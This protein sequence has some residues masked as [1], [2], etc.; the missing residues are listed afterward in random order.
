M[1]I[2]MRLALCC[3]LTSGAFA[4]HHGSSGS[5]GR[6][7]F[8]GSSGRG[9]RGHAGLHRNLVQRGFGNNGPYGSY[10]YWPGYWDSGLW[11][12]SY[13]DPSDTPSYAGP[14]VTVVYPPPAPAYPAVVQTAHPVIHEYNQP[15][16]YGL[17]GQE[18]HPVLYLIAFRDSVIRPATTFWVEGDTLHYIG[19]DHKEQRAPLSSVDEDLSTELNRERHVPFHL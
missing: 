14:N 4:Q 18:S 3:L 8:T 5:A 6:A 12:S 7:G 2:V 15:E 1:K 13:Y 16:D 10:A 19:V 11:G 9:F 17:T